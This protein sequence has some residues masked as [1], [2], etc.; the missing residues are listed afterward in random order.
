MIFSEQESRLKYKAMK[1][2]KEVYKK[3]R[4]VASEA[5]IRSENSHN[6]EYAR[7]LRECNIFTGDETFEQ[8]INIIFSPQGAEFL[9]EN[10][11]PDIATFRKFKKYHPER[12]G[13]Y[14]DAGKITL[15]EARKA[16]LV[17]NTIAEM[18]YS[19]IA[20][21][22][23]ILM[24][25]ASAHIEASGYSIVKIEKDDVSKV[26]IVKSDYAKVLQ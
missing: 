12:F 11:F 13:V 17:G 20:G 18:K 23:L 24:W 19:Q 25:G 16:F 1:E 2:I 9:T 7:K 26:E 22:R 10:H 21:N 3:Y 14:I 6:Y 15:S 8:L 4:K 5:Q